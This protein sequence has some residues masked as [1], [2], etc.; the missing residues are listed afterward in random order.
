MRHH[1]VVVLGSGGAGLTAALAAR[2]AGA[3]VALF[4]KAELLGGSTAVSGGLVWM[5]NNPAQADVGVAGQCRRWRG[6]PDVALART[7][8]P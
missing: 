1:D 7:Y 6:V 8:L 4:E 5:P 3:R 2:A